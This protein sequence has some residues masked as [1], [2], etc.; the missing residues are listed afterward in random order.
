MECRPFRAGIT[1]VDSGSQAL[2]LFPVWLREVFASLDD[3]GCAFPTFPHSATVEKI[4]IRELPDA[5]PHDE[6]S[7]LLDLAVKG[8]A[9]FVKNDRRHPAAPRSGAGSRLQQHALVAGGL[10]LDLVEFGQRNLLLDV[11]VIRS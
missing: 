10:A 3:E 4:R 6:I 1:F 5:R 8:L 11:V 2:L 9:V 7:V